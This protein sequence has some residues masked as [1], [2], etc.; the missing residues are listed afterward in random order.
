[1]NANHSANLL[2]HQ[3]TFVDLFFSPSAKKALILRADV[4][5]GKG[6]ALVAIAQRLHEI[7]PASRVLYL[8]PGSVLRLQFAQRLKELGVPCLEVDRYRFREL[9][10]TSIDG[11]LWPAG[12]V[13]MMSREFARQDDVRSSLADTRWDLVMLDGADQFRGGLSRDLVLQATAT[14]DRMIMTVQL[15]VSW[16]VVL[17]DEATVIVTWHKNQIVGLDG[18]LIATGSRPTLSVVQYELTPNEQAISEAVGRLNRKLLEAGTI[19]AAWVGRV[20]L[21]SHESSLMS[22]EARLRLLAVGHPHSS[23]EFQLSLDDVDVDEDYEGHQ[24]QQEPPF[25]LLAASATSDVLDLLDNI[26][27]DSK[28]SALI[29]LLRRL[30][31]DGDARVFV[32]TVHVATLFYISSELEGLGIAHHFVHGSMAIEDRHRALAAFQAE[33]GLLLATRAALAEA[34]DLKQ[35]SELVLYD[36]PDGSSAVRRLIGRFDRFGRVTE[37]RVFCFA[38]QSQGEESERVREL[39]GILKSD[40]EK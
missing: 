9:L 8:V 34:W 6:A 32:F 38:P 10:D 33:G 27:V 18:K 40:D 7:R 36:L 23:P 24:G 4:G 37:L 15:G 25:P 30:Q 39:R 11:T 2:P 5:L 13:I 19:R 16:P 35:V 22:L 3:A 21:Q 1:V 20:L 29:D 12:L 28:L 14:S 17:S 26:D 31:A